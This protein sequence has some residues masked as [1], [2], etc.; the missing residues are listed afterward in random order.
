MFYLFIDLGMEEIKNCETW[1]VIKRKRWRPRKERTEQELL[2]TLKIKEAPI[3]DWKNFNIKD[4]V[5]LKEDW[6]FDIKN[7]KENEKWEKYISIWWRKYYEYDW[8]FK[9][10]DSFYYKKWK[11]LF[12]WDKIEGTS[13]WDWVSFRCSVY[14]TGSVYVEEHKTKLNIWDR[15]LY[16]WKLYK[17]RSYTISETIATTVRNWK[18]VKIT[19][20]MIDRFIAWNAGKTEQVVI[21]Y[22]MKT[23]P[24]FFAYME[25]RLGE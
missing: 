7:P 18:R 20:E 16:I 21:N 12:I 2:Q 8:W 25:D 4:I 3:P 11:T 15:A 10:P 14:E 13:F 5:K 17:S 24:E 19:K 22:A 23:N 9:R 1:E 6:M